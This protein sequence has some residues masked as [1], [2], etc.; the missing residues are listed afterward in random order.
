MARRLSKVRP[1][2]TQTNGA[3]A[4]IYAKDW[5]SEPVGLVKKA[6]RQEIAEWTRMRSMDE[7]QADS[8]E[9][10]PDLDAVRH[11]KQF[12]SPEAPV[13]EIDCVPEKVDTVREFMADNEV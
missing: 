6:P 7:D 5:R 12:G 8:A 10:W 3:L 9:V 4:R 13:I 1:T 2:T 11:V